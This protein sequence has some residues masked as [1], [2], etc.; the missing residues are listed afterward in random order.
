MLGV[1]LLVVV[2][3][4]LALLGLVLAAL[5]YALTKVGRVVNRRVK[6]RRAERRLAQLRHSQWGPPNRALT[7]LDRSVIGSAWRCSPQAR[8]EDRRG[9]PPVLPR[10]PQVIHPVRHDVLRPY[11]VLRR[12]RI[13]GG[14]GDRRVD[15]PAVPAHRRAR[16]SGTP[17][18]RSPT[19]WSVRSSCS[20]AHPS[21][22]GRATTSFWAASLVRS[23]RSPV[24]RRQC[25]P[26]RFGAV[27]A[28]S[29]TR[30]LGAA[31]A[32]IAAASLAIVPLQLKG[33]GVTH[34][35]TWFFGSLPYG[36]YVI[37]IVALCSLGFVPLLAIGIGNPGRAML[38][39]FAARLSLTVV[40]TAIEQ[41]ELHRVQ[42]FSIGFWLEC[43]G[44][45]S[46]VGLGLLGN[47]RAAAPDPFRPPPLAATA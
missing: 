1:S 30:R 18:S 40:S 36:T 27:P 14:P 24:P 9:L 8:S 3:G 37:A 19:S 28:S 11:P 45:V 38:F 39:V 21:L 46:L 13:A 12:P 7:N 33:Q 20:Y 16:S 41:H 15:E 17:R 2:G 29:A 35:I 23:P 25:S 47:R 5:A 22:T 6:R 31:T 43:I 26:V 32:V 4:T 10:R 34:G 44:V 42:Q